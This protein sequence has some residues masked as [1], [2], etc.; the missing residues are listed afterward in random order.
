LSKVTSLTIQRFLAMNT[1]ALPA[2]THYEAVQGKIE[3]MGLS[4]DILERAIL[5][6]L[7]QFKKVTPLHPVTAGGS[8]TWEEIN[9]SLR[10]QLL[11]FEGWG[12]SHLRGLTLT[13]NK[14]LGITLVVTS[15]NKYTGII[16]VQPKTKNAKGKSTQD[17]VG[18]NYSLF[19]VESDNA[20]SI[21]Q[22]GIDPNETW[23]LLYHIDKQAKEIRFELSLPKG[24]HESEGRLQIDS[25]EHRIVFDAVPF[26]REIEAGEEPDFNEEIDFDELTK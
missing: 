11:P 3:E 16:E 18:R 22:V 21:E 17:Y 5:E 23:V 7:S 2:V 9:A 25:W 6:G 15:G 13:H 19:E 10:I 12:F 8:R 4:A 1:S 20:T 14:D 24:M 26:T